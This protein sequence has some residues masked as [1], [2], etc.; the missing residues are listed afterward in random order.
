MVLIQT[1]GIS[2]NTYSFRTVSFYM[3]LILQINEDNVTYSFRTVS[4]YM[5]LIHFGTLVN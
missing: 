4:F 5:V 1:A 2:A 3:V